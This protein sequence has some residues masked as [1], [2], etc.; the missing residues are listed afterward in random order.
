VSGGDVDPAAITVVRG[1]PTPEEL[2]A[3]V[4]VL[5]AVARPPR[6]GDPVRRAPRWWDPGWQAPGAWGTGPRAWS[7][8]R[9]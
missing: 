1:R 7:R 4:A 9:R 8:P 5:V 3:V 2:A 6:T